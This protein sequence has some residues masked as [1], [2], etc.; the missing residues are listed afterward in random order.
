MSLTVLSVAYPL[1]AV[2]PDAVGGAEQ[3]LSQLDRALVAAGHRSVVVARKD[4]GIAGTLVPVVNFEEEIDEAAR[5]AAWQAHRRAIAGA[6]ARYAVDLVHMHGIDFHE[7][8]PPPGL[9]VLATLHL[10]HSWYPPEA[11]RPARPDTWL[12]CVSEAQERACPPGLPLLARIENGV[13]TAAFAGRHARRGFAL[14]LGRICP[15]KGVHIAVEAAKRADVPL[16]LAGE[17]FPYATHRRYFAEEV[18]PRLDRE[19]RFVG[20]VGG[21]RKR[22]L[23][24]AARCVLVPSLAPETSSLVAREALAAGTPVVAFPAGALAETVE[25]GRTGFLVR[26]TEEM[27]KAI[28]LADGID[29]AE[30]RR[31]AS[32]R[33]PLSR[34]V[35]GYLAAYA[36]L[37]GSGEGARLRGAA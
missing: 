11:L 26:D 15:E 12:N 1:A 28:R 23:L 21:A 20:P 18:T 2:G 36:S 33:F 30:C 22:R 32:A 13:D 37:T 6:L 14:F 25:H 16:I 27:A 10:P 9:P 4:S 7:Y 35:E 17:V 3:V 5:Q 8:L 29:Q 34:M 24:A 31:A 19:R